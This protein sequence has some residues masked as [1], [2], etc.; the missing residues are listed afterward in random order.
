MSSYAIIAGS[1]YELVYILDLFCNYR[2]LLW[3]YQIK[4]IRKSGRSFH[5]T[6]QSQ[7]YATWLLSSC[8]TCPRIPEYGSWSY[9]W[10]IRLRGHWW[11]Q[12]LIYLAIELESAAYISNEIWIGSRFSLFAFK[13][14]CY[15]LC[16]LFCHG[17]E[18][19]CLQVCFALSVQK[20]Q[21]IQLFIWVFLVE[22]WIRI[23][24]QF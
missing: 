16:R 23:F 5:Q 20:V 6:G 3:W 8:P 4:F 14:H 18:F 11:R 13:N 2:N 22:F 10:T 15:I 19:T 7:E 24:T 1:R 12:E 9:K 17:D 21:I